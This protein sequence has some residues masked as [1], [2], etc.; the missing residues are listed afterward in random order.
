MTNAVVEEIAITALL[1]VEAHHFQVTEGFQRITAFIYLI[2]HW[3]NFQFIATLGIE[4][5]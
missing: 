2:A 1:G 3:E 5:E 4:E